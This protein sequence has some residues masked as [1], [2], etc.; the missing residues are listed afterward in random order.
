MP[1][2]AALLCATSLGAMI[3]FS[4]VVAPTT[5]RVLVPADAGSFLRALFPK[6]FLVNGA[7]AGVAA[8]I[9]ARPVPAIILAGAAALMIGV[10]VLLIPMINA[11]RDAMLADGGNS[12]ARFDGLHRMSVILNVVEMAA[13]VAA[14]VLLRQAG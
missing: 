8:L 10:R 11:A 7:I 14:I 12:K 2:L 4:A 9:A 1:E 6:Y 13:L 3:F 5:F